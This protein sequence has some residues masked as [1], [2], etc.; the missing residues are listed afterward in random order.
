METSNAIE[1]IPEGDMPSENKKWTGLLVINAFILVI[2]YLIM[3]NKYPYETVRPW[4]FILVILIPVD[5]SILFFSKDPVKVT[6]IK[7]TGIFQYDYID[8][9][10]SEKN[11]TIYLKTAY[12]KYKADV[13]HTG[14]AMRLLIYNNYF[15]NQVVIKADEKMGFNRAQLD[16]IAEEIKVI[17][18]RLNA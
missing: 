13:T 4:L 9:F 18:E 1:F 2:W 17:Q 11:R 8:F 5:I 6:L 10:G 16:A 15:K 12:Y 14:A 7:D 3:H